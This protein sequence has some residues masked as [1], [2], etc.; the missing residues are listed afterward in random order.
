MGELLKVDAQGL[1]LEIVLSAGEELWRIRRIVMEVLRSN[2]SLY[3]DQPMPKDV[4]D[5]MV[6]AGFRLERCWHVSS[7]ESNC[8]FSKPA[9]WRH[10]L[11]GEHC[12]PIGYAESIARILHEEEFVAINRK[13]GISE[14]LSSTEWR[15]S[16][17]RGV[18]A[19]LCCSGQLQCW[20]AANGYAPETCCLDV[21]LDY[22]GYPSGSD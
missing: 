15:D 14:S 4:Q 12:F 2:L 11:D 9:Y 22:I 17:K 3:V 1:D 5:A 7:L 21:Y 6:D 13:Y 8:V 18:A 20:D 19:K 10:V 16:F